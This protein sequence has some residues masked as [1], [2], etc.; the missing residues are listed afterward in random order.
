MSFVVSPQLGAP[1]T[2]APVRAWLEGYPTLRFKLDPTSEWDASLIE[3]LVRTSAV[4]VV[5]FKG[6]Y[7]DTPVDRAVDPALY[8]RVALAFPQAWLE[9]PVLDT[10]TEPILAP[11]RDRLTWDAPIHSIA[12]IETLLF[13]QG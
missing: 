11:H 5:D 7:S 12:D 10:H 6:H 1:P 3:E 13:L 8:E 9:D 2:S 4:D